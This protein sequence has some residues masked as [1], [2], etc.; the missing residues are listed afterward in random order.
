[1]PIGRSYDDPSTGGARNAI[2]LI[3][4]G[5]KL[6]NW[7]IVLLHFS[8]AGLQ[9]LHQLVEGTPEK[10]HTG[11]GEKEQQKAVLLSTLIPPY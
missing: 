6:E 4:E 8:K 9:Y 1:V 2:Q 11:L 5:K 10:G 7:A 3:N